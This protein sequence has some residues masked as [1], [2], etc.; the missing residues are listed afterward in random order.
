MTGH[1]ARIRTTV[2][3]H[4]CLSDH[5]VELDERPAEYSRR[6]RLQRRG[7]RTKNA[8]SSEGAEPTLVIYFEPVL[9][10]HREDFNVEEK[11]HKVHW[12]SRAEYDFRTRGVTQIDQLLEIHEQIGGSG[13]GGRRDLEILNKSA[14]VLTCA[15]WEAFIE[16]LAVE[17]LLHFAKTA[18]STDALPIELKKTVVNNL[19]KHELAPWTLA[20]DGWREILRERASRIARPDDRSLSTPCS[21]EIEAFVKKEA[22]ISDFTSSWRW[23]NVSAPQSRTRLDKFVMLRHAI[24]HRGGPVDVTVSKKHAREGYSLISRL[25]QCSL[26]HVN[27]KTEEYTGIKLVPDPTVIRF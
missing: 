10:S 6:R 25:T 24:A 18:E 17:I 2:S 5:P 9:G 26:K 21:T 27:T 16:N 23:N 22:G 19:G 4:H 7:R 14:V 8:S 13:P 3:P 1:V 20:G 12:L 15:F 11:I